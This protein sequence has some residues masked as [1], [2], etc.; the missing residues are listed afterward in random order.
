MHPSLHP[1]K[2]PRSRHHAARALL[3]R[4]VGALAL[5]AIAALVASSFA[6][7]APLPSDGPQLAGIIAPDKTFFGFWT[8]RPDG[9]E[10]IRD[11]AALRTEALHVVV[12]APNLDPSASR[13]SLTFVWERQ[14]EVERERTVNRT[15]PDNSTE[16]VVEKYKEMV[17]N[18][19]DRRAYEV[20]AGASSVEDTALSLL[21]KKGER[22]SIYYLSGAR[23]DEAP[24]IGADLG[25]RLVQFS[26]D[27]SPL[28]AKLA[29]PTLETNYVRLGQVLMLALGVTIVGLFA[30]RWV[31]KRAGGYVPPVDVASATIG[32]VIGGGIAFYIV[33]TYWREGLVLKGLLPPLVAFG[34]IVAFFSLQVWREDSDKWQFKRYAPGIE[35]AQPEVHIWDVRVPSRLTDPHPRSDD[36]TDVQFVTDSWRD[37]VLR[38]L[39][40]RMYLRHPDDR[41]WHYKVDN[42]PS[43]VREHVLK[44]DLAPA[45]CQRCL[46]RGEVEPHR[47][48][49][50]TLEKDPGQ[51]FPRL[52]FHRVAIRDMPL[53]PWGADKEVIAVISNLQTMDACAS[54]RSA[55][56]VQVAKLEAEVRGGIW[57]KARR[58]FDEFL[59]REKAAVAGVDVETIRPK[60]T[61]ERKLTTPPPAPSTAGGPR[62]AAAVST[63]HEGAP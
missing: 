50:L 1:R 61:D 59:L 42:H 47:R 62:A 43:I 31:Y 22:L 12:Y 4:F 48:P 39:G 58:F 55:L 32:T 26:H 60:A 29:Q 6:A 52:R 40:G 56:Q 13:V 33:W 44:N 57:D 24:A 27:T 53:S 63:P 49:H 19:T 35:R 7:A 14:V 3:W 9:A 5:V 30:S 20:Q 2:V 38:V 41:N 25:V 10:F 46:Q 23:G 11:E 17:W 28:Y 8:Y 36:P 45:V 21:P 16:R 34:F 37:F 18:E 54:E 15:L 51:W